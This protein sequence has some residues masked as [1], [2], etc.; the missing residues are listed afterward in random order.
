MLLEMLWE[1]CSFFTFFARHSQAVAGRKVI[2][3]YHQ[4]A[5]HELEFSIA[6]RIVVR[7]RGD[8]GREVHTTRHQNSKMVRTHVDSKD[9][10]MARLR[11]HTSKSAESVHNKKARTNR[12]P[13]TAALWGECHVRTYIRRLCGTGLH[14]TTVLDTSRGRTYEQGKRGE[15]ESTGSAIGAV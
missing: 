9:C 13:D 8:K 7:V 15:R 2:G 3:T 14:R 5:E 4:R 10:P 1:C 11:R 12:Q 6:Q